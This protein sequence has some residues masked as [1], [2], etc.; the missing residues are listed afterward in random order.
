[1]EYFFTGSIERIIF[2]NASNFFKILL[3]NIED[4]DS[5]LDDFEIIVTGIMAEVIEGESYTF[6]G[7]LV[8]HPKYGEQL[9]ASRYERKK[10]SASGL[11]NYFSSSQFKGIGKKTAEKIVTLYGNDPI[12]AILEDPSKLD[13]ISGLSKVKKSNLSLNSD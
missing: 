1:M 4:T 8:E 12:D 3:L 9:S 6:W 2:E 10:P 7:E 13:T 5:S 11:I